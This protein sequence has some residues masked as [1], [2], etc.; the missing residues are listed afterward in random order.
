MRKSSLNWVKTMLKALLKKQL[1]EFFAGLSLKSKDG[2]SKGTGAKAGAVFLMLF[3]GLTFFGMFFSLSYLMMPVI[4]SGNGVLYLAV[5]GIFTVLMGL[6]GSVFLTYNALYEAKDNDMLLAMP[7]LPG[8]ILFARIAGLY[9]TTLGFGLLVL[10]PS[11]IVYFMTAG[12][13][14]VS[15]ILYLISV[16]LLPLFSLA[17]A[18]VLGFFIALFSSKIRNKSLI[19]VVLSLAF[20]C[21][22][23]FSMLKI[24]D[25]INILIYQSDIVTQFIEKWLYP[26]YLLGKGLAGD[27][28]SYAL[29][30]VITLAV[31]GVIYFVL[32]RTFF[33]LA[34]VNKGQKKL[35]YKEKR[36]KQTSAKLAF[37]KKELLYF[38]NTPVYILNS[39]FGSLMV[40]VA[41]VI[42]AVKKEALLPMMAQSGFPVFSMPLIIGL[43]LCVVASSNNISAVSVSLEGRNIYMLHSLPCNVSDVFFGK[44]M[45][46]TAV[47]GIPLVIGNV[48]VS[49]SLGADII[50]GMLLTVFSVLFVF[51]LA[52]TGLV[53]NLLF[54]KMEWTN[55]TVPIKQSLSSLLGM[56]S[57]F[58]YG[59]VLMFSGII[60]ASFLSMQVC[61]L[62]A[63]GI[64]L[65]LALLLARWLKVKGVK[66]FV[67]L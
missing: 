19:T 51:V 17:V 23:Y 61:L 12:I 24:G 47:T 66:K 54:P 3:M 37:M 36:A 32:S 65:I 31:F 22:Y 55:E 2:K 6:M 64:L 52:E 33:K 16:L 15:L 14:A 8:M 41:S 40:L 57:G 21:V 43:A 63:A 10:I 1:L 67:S 39:A 60:T 53:I 26:F 56:F 34:I 4:E 7:I 50:T 44:I 42:F 11:A 20:F 45:L 62:I 9:I 49:I 28:L 38:K 5:F 59:L 18:L 46:H 29:F 13:S 25:I 58:A 35:K 27:A 30:A 48:I